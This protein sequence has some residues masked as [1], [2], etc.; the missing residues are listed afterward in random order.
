MP[1][2]SKRK[3]EQTDVTDDASDTDPVT[4]TDEEEGNASSDSDGSD[5]NVLKQLILHG[6]EVK[7]KLVAGKLQ[8]VFRTPKFIKNDGSK[9]DDS[10]SVASGHSP[11]MQRRVTWEDESPHPPE[12]T[13]N[14]PSRSA[15]SYAARRPVSN[16]GL[17]KNWMFS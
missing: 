12:Y 5:V 15:M 17:V 8:Y 16:K 11:Q 10:S 7:G 13:V 1:R 3:D 2:H 6:F 9:G 14:Q 4:W